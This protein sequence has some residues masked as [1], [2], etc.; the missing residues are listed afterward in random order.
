MV[1]VLPDPFTPIIRI[2]KGRCAGSI[3]SGSATGA[4]TAS[5]SLA[6]TPRTSSPETSRSKRS[7]RSVSV[8]A[9]AVSRPRSAWIS[10]SSS[11]SSVASSSRRLVKTAVIEP[12]NWSDERLRP[13]VNRW[14][15]PCFGSAVAGAGTTGAASGTPS[16]SRAAVNCSSIS[17][18]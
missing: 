2:T 18:T 4:S 10:T 11:S 7:R 5:T 16:A 3:R 8:I 17:S 15:Q 14:N 13:V 9:V 6:S 12:V 1:V